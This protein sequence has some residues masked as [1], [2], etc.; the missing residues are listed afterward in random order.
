MLVSFFSIF[1]DVSTVDTIVLAGVIT[2]SVVV[3]F[4]E[5]APIA[6]AELKKTPLIQP[7]DLITANLAW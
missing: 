3:I 7:L 4:P 1:S 2:R 6:T 5:R